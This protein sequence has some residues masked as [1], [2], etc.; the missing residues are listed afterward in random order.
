MTRPA[1]D[2]GRNNNS[3]GAIF[4]MLAMLG[5]ASMDTITKWMVADYPI[6]QMMW[7]RYAIFCLFAWFVVRRRGLRAAARSARPWLQLGRALLAVVE[8]AVFV[9]AFRYL[10]LADT[11][12][13]AATSPLIVIALGVLFLGEKAGPA[14]WAAVAAGFVGVLLIVRPG[15]R[16][17]DWPLLLPVAGAILWGAYQ[18]LIRLCSRTDTPDTTLVWSAFVAFGA[19]TLVGPLQWRWPDATGWGLLIAIAILGAFAHYALIKAL[20]YAEAGAVQPYSYT[21]LVF[22]TI[23]GVIVF[24]DVPDHWTLAG[25]AVIVASGLYTWHHERRAAVRAG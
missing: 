13:V 20:D 7:V 23:L 19:T 16:E 15:F 22:V 3:R 5:F 12:A 1:A 17:L 4:T 9:L 6:G 21:L 10:P 14:R 24:G 25:A 11:H 2:P 18:I 8:S